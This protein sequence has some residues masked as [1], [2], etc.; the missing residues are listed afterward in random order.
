MND[1]NQIDVKGIAATKLKRQFEENTGLKATE[2]SYPQGR[3]LETY[4]EAYAIWLEQ[5]LVKLIT[6]R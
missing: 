6:M 3:V 1:G 2:I 5:Q 4:T